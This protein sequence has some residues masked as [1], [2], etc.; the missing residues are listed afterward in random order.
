MVIHFSSL[1][2]VQCP[3]ILCISS[4][5]HGINSSLSTQ[6][7][8]GADPTQFFMAWELW[9]RAGGAQHP[10]D[11]SRSS[12]PAHFLSAAV[13]VGPSTGLLQRR[14]QTGGK[15]LGLGFANVISHCICETQ[16]LC[17]NPKPGKI[18][19]DTETFEQLRHALDKGSCFCSPSPWPACFLSTL[20]YHE[21]KI[22]AETERQSLPRV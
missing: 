4:R 14:T 1:H 16:E 20:F 7:R 19:A 22:T 13:H 9:G 10:P 12:L 18:I 2:T 15:N 21:Q 3:H 17:E 6:Q 5:L 8:Q 11:P